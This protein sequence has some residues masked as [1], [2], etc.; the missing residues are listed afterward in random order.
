MTVA[1]PMDKQQTSQA[2][3]TPSLGNNT[4]LGSNGAGYGYGIQ[5]LDIERYWLEVKVLRSWIAGIFATCLFLAVVATL[6]I[7][8]MYASNA[9]IEVS[10]I[11]A[12]VTDIDPI[13]SPGS[14]SELQYLN[15]QFELLQ[16]RFMASRV[17]DAGN[18]LRDDEFRDAFSIG[19]EDEFLQSDL[20][21][22]LQENIQIE[23]ITQSSL[24]DIVFTSPSPQLSARIANLWAEQFIAANYEKRFGANVE[25][26]DFL[27]AQIAELREV[28]ARSEKELFD[29]ANAN[30]I[31]IVKSVRGAG[32]GLPAAQSLVATDVTALNSALAQAVTDR[33]SAEATVQSGDLSGQSKNPQLT[34][35]LA[36]AQA[37]LSTLQSNFGPGYAELQQKEAEVAALRNALESESSTLAS[38]ARAALAAAKLRE[39][40]LRAE[41][42]RSKLQFLG[43]QNQGI[44]YGILQRE[45]ETNRALYEALLQRFKELEASGAGQNNIKLIDVAKPAEKPVSPSL[46]QNVLIGLVCAGL[47]SAG[48]VCLRMLLSQTIRS[49]DDVKLHLGLSVLA[50]IPKV[51]ESSA[52]A[53]LDEQSSELAE[54][55]RTLRSN[56]AFLTVNGAPQVLMM[57]STVPCEGKSFSAIALASSFARLG[58]R[59]LLVDADLRNSIL[60]RTLEVRDPSGGGLSAL[61]TSKDASVFD[62]IISLPDRD[63]DLL[64]IGRRLVNPVDL[65]AGSRFLD[66]INAAR[67][68]YDHIIVDAAPTLSLA[69]AVETGKVC[70]GILYIIEYDR[71]KTRAIN[72]SLEWLK[73]SGAY[74]YGAAITKVDEREAEYGYGYRYNYGDSRATDPA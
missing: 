4:S 38:E 26:R 65:L 3:I 54:A 31:L 70:D 52:L 21:A 53:T 58:K 12:N 10:Q 16:S 74:I 45:V 5:M 8:A 20:D 14:V 48:L 35:A 40:E 63:F 55:Y 9:R 62:T 67:D 36:V 47:I 1:P 60:D 56:L 18:L 39:N 59:V 6:L 17:A 28:L 69:D 2:M 24:V 13:D 42:E 61:L 19:P 34:A 72:A 30:E 64:P 46:V 29:Y 41:L 22:L 23:E 32:G 50:T 11:S 25:A 51:S 57:T 71:A 49:S 7:T 27:S 43:Q 68:R 66:L 15:T 44:Q 37:E 73:T 33:I